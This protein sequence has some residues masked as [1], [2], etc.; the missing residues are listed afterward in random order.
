M[1]NKHENS[2]LR[3]FIFKFQQVKPCLNFKY[4]VAIIK[5]NKLY[6]S[7]VNNSLIQMILHWYHIE[8]I[9]NG[10]LKKE[11][12]FFVY[13]HLHMHQYVRYALMHISMKLIPVYKIK[14]D[15]K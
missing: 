6:I 14:I 11:K 2:V 10:L 15:T 5:Y 7:E 1:Y 3:C 12:T 4:K 13:L 9:L 8:K